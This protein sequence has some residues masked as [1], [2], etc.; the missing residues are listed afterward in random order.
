M[1]CVPSVALVQA[2]LKDAPG[3]AEMVKNTVA[4]FRR[5]DALVNNASTFYPTPIGEIT[6][7]QW[8]DMIGSNLQAPRF[9]PGGG[10][11]PQE[12]GRL[13]RE[14]R[15]YP[16]RAAAEELRPV[17]HRQGRAGGADALACAGAWSRGA[18]QRRCARAIP[19]GPRTM[20]DAV[21]RQ[22]IISHTLLRRIG[23]PDDIAKAVYYFI[24]EAP[25][26]RARC[27]RWTA[28]TGINI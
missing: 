10:A 4:R 18:G 11:A 27:W 21:S 16:R 9:L 23:E 8:E 24:A 22:R 28:D 17:Q 3:L 25:M 2:D 13:D 19:C 12:D 6:P 5:I 1:R 15:R 14:H 20:L 26:S 7:A